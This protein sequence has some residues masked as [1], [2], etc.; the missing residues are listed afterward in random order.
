MPFIIE[1]FRRVTGA[2]QTGYYVHGSQCCQWSLHLRVTA[3]YLC[4]QTSI[5]ERSC[6]FNN[7]GREIWPS[8]SA[9]SMRDLHGLQLHSGTADFEYRPM[10]GFYGLFAVNVDAAFATVLFLPFRSALISSCRCCNYCVTVIPIMTGL[11]LWST[12]SNTVTFMFCA[13]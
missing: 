1:F 13:S 3:L 7:L 9:V 11:C 8:H 12:E 5:F 6:M 10:R 4:R 2:D